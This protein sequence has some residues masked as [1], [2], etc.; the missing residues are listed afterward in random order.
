MRVIE[1]MRILQ[2]P[3]EISGQVGL[4]VKGLRAIGLESDSLASRH[5]Y[6]YENDYYFND[7]KSKI[8]KVIGRMGK[9]KM[10]KK[11]YDVI[12]YHF[13]ESILP[14]NMDVNYFKKSG[15][16]IFTEFWGSDVRISGIEKDRN[17]YY[18]NSHNKSDDVNIE[19]MK[20]WSDFTE[21]V[22]IFSDHTFDDFLKPYFD[23]VHIVGQR[24]DIEKYLP[25]YPSRENS[26]PV[27]V[28]APS[29]Q[30]IKGTI[31]VEKAVQ[32]LKKK[33]LHFKYVQV[34][35]LSNT[36]AMEVYKTADIII[37]QL[38]IG[39]HGVFACEAMALGKPVICY[40]LPEFLDKYPDGFPIINANPDTI[41]EVLEQ[42][43]QTPEERY[44]VGI[45][46]RK[47]AERV[48]DIEV[49]ANKL[50]GVYQTKF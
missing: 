23:K 3:T 43:I 21:G 38:C 29:N 31:H 19:R 26:E 34:E 40:I 18:V 48:H 33:G 2:T 30:A 27:V 8:G 1:G 22:A 16:K 24:V 17:P 32:N 45:Q 41:E 44:Q 12:H 36:E 39:A 28:H 13:G 11:N 10:I 50:H 7:S 37:D 6:G 47:Y 35:K 15:M 9:I 5:P 49:V 25:V 46:S 4:T 20:R 14:K 42:W